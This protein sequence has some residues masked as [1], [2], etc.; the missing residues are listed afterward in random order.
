M[1]PLLLIMAIDF[2]DSQMLHNDDDRLG[3][4]I[5]CSLNDLIAIGHVDRPSELL[6]HKTR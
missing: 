5:D 1:S 3:E 4:Q 2:P 6:K